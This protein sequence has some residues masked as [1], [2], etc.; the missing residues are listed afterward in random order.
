[1]TRKQW[2]SM[3]AKFL[4]GKTIKS[5]R[6]LN[7]AEMESWGFDRSPVIIEFEDGSWF[8][9]MR[10]DEGNDGGSL[11]TSDKNLPVIPVI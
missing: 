8:C 2:E 10:D 3:I 11:A 1:M 5:A 6:Y 7:D 4:V 9:P